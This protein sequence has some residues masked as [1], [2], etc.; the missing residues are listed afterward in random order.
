[1]NP[2]YVK[3]IKLIEGVQRRAT[4]VES[5]KDLHY[6]ERLNILGLMRVDKRRDRSDLIETFKI[7]NGNYRVDKD[8]F[9]VPDD[10]GRRGHSRKLFKRRCRLSNKKFAFSNGI[11]G[12]WSSSDN[13]VSCTMLNN[14]KTHIRLHWDWKPDSIVQS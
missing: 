3:D 8:L 11:V 7:L 12:N 13:C 14:F 5:V 6:D 4:I 10:G 2:H 9:F 1:M